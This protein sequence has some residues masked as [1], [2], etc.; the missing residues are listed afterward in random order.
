DKTLV[1]GAKRVRL[2]VTG[3]ALETTTWNAMGTA[4]VT[5]KAFADASAAARGYDKAV[6]AK[7]RADY[8]FLGAADE[9]GDI[10]LEAFA[11]GGGGGRV[12]DI[13]ADGTRIVTAS[14]TS[15]QNFGVKLEVVD[16]A[17]GARDIVVDE[18]G[19]KRQNFLHAAL[20]DR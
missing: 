20:F 16:V 14:I 18:P 17:T 12:L 15:E 7:M 2:R 11:P 8:A 10:V 6:R 1:L 13:S 3:K 19:G 4:K 5:T 9:P